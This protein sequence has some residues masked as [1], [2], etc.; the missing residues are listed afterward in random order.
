MVCQAWCWR[1]QVAFKVLTP[2]PLNPFW[3]NW[4]T[5]CEPLMLT[6]GQVSTCIWPYSDIKHVI[7][8]QWHPVPVGCP[9][10]PKKTRIG[11]KLSWHQKRG[12]TEPCQTFPRSGIILLGAD[13]ILLGE[14]DVSVACLLHHCTVLVGEVP[15][16]KSGWAYRKL[17]LCIVER[18]SQPCTTIMIDI[19]DCPN[20]VCCLNAGKKNLRA[21]LTALSSS[22][23]ISSY[24]IPVGYTFPVPLWHHTAQLVREA[25]C[26]AIP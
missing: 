13:S 23:L 14:H 22:W 9:A 24:L 20:I 5:N 15:S 7:G 3:I 26:D 10:L 11:N 8:H 21:R 18:V 16:T 12:L 19:S 1:T 17:F 6:N 2:T 25:T 4:N